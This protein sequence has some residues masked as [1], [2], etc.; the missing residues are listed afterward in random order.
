MLLNT[1]STVEKK[2]N[3][4]DFLDINKIDVFLDTFK[5]YKKDNIV[6]PGV[7]IRNLGISSTAV[8]RILYELSNIG[9]LEINYEIFCEECNHFRGII[10]R[11]I[12]S[13]PDDLIC[14][15]CNK[16]IT[17]LDYVVVFR[18]LVDV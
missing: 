13:I 17:I 7:F 4:I 5:H 10:Y 6:Y 12:A 1:L 2:L 9:I 8:Y 16:E 18:M 3:E 14:D 15:N 11:S